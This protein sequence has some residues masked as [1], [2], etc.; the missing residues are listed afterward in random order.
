MGPPQRSLGA[1]TRVAPTI[2]RNGTDGENDA[3][4]PIN[5]ATPT[6]GPYD[7]S[8]GCAN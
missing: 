8:N 3:G 2:A 7:C 6:V 4:Q 5:R 1:T